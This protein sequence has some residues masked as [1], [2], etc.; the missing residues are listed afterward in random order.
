MVEPIHDETFGHLKW[1]P[2]LDCWLGGIDWPRGLH[3]EVAIWL[4]DGNVPAGLRQARE[5]FAW[6]QQNE[7][8]ARRCFAGKML[9]LYNDTWRR[10]EDEPI[11]EDEFLRRTEIMRIGF[12]DDGSLL[13]SYDNGDMFGGCVINAFFDADRS[14]RNAHL[15][16]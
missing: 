11:T 14:F 4:P 8:H 5:G 13:L 2:L 1:D 7:E 15:I 3:T 12:E 6:L 10:D 9:E 16:D